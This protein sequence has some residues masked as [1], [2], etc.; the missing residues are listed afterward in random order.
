[1]AP[2]IDPK[3]IRLSRKTIKL[4]KK[5][6]PV[7]AAYIFGS[8]VTGKT[9]ESSDIDLAIFSPIVDNMSLEKKVNIKVRVEMELGHTPM[10]I[11]LYDSS[12]LEKAR[13]T[14]IFGVILETGYRIL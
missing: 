3:V 5:R 8:H 9:D 12:R 4:L 1:M 2:K 10:E 13:P 11:H 14:N 6:I 7:E